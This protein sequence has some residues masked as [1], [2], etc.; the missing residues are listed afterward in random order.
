MPE[1]TPNIYKPDDEWFRQE[2]KKA[3]E[4]AGIPLDNK[5]G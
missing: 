2:I 1:K 4:R 3:K 5:K